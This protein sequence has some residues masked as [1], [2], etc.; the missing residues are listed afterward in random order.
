[1]TETRRPGGL[2][3]LGIVAL[4]LAAAILF[5]SCGGS[6]TATQKASSD[7]AFRTG[8]DAAQHMTTF[9]RQ[10]KYQVN[11]DTLISDA[12][13]V[14]GKGTVIT[15]HQL[16]GDRIHGIVIGETAY[17]TGNADWFEFEFGAAATRVPECRRQ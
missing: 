5:G 7:D 17:L 3:V 10:A 4:L 6:T 1:M 8:I 13:I 9:R 2:S 15:R 14:V 11:G 12:Q 16:N